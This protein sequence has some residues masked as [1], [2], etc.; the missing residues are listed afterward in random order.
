MTLCAAPRRLVW[1]FVAALTHFRHADTVRGYLK[2]ASMARIGKSMRAAAE[3]ML[4]LG[5]TLF[6]TLQGAL[7]G[8]AAVYTAGSCH[9][10]A[11]SAAHAGAEP[12][13]HITSGHSHQHDDIADS[14]HD[15]PAPV[16]DADHER[17]FDCC[18]WMCTAAIFQAAPDALPYAPPS[19]LS[20]FRHEASPPGWLVFG[21]DRPP[22]LLLA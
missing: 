11:A 18:G 16:G 14:H 20:D 4:V 1:G 13:A 12:S 21:L 5:L 22:R 3:G 10:R 17:L 6:L 15:A 19:R 7:A 9:D 8:F 2:A